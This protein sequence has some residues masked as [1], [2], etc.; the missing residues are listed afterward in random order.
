MS[1]I[2]EEPSILGE[3]RILWTEKD[4]RKKGRG[5]DLKRFFFFT[6]LLFFL[7]GASLFYVWTRI[8]VIH[9]GYEISNALKENQTLT[10]VNRRMRL[11]VATLKSYKRIERIAIEELKMVNPK[12][13]Q[14]IVIR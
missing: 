13:D 4:L 3:H 9:L 6:L 2:R 10:D 5:I 12:P 1:R 7:V 14:V 8:Q 11:E